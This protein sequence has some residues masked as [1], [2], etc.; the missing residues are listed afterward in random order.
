MPILQP[1]SCRIT[2]ESGPQ[3]HFSF[4]RRGV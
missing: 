4:W 3:Q 1:K 2:A